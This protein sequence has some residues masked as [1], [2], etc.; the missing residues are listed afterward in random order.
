MTGVTGFTGA[1][2]TIGLV[3]GVVI[4][5]TDATGVVTGS[6]G[7]AGLTFLGVAGFVASVIPGI[8]VARPETKAPAPP[9]TFKSELTPPALPPVT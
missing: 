4:G 8:L 5:L 9:L 3:S 2:G 6:F 1:T 7:A